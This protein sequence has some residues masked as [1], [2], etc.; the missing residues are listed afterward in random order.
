[1]EPTRANSPEDELPLDPVDMITRLMF[2]G[3]LEHVELIERHPYEVV[4]IDK[5]GDNIFA[6]YHKVPV[7]RV[8]QI[9]RRCHETFTTFFMQLK[10]NR[11][12]NCYL[13]FAGRTDDGEPV[14]KVY[15]GGF[16]V[17]MS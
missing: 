2:L 6:V 9:P 1:M 14:L 15:G 10:G 16:H 7:F 17:Y 5:W 13:E 3:L 4:L 12:E 8:L 11:V